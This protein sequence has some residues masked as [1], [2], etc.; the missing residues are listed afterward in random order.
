MRVNPE[1]EFVIG[2]YTVGGAT[3][4]AVIFGYYGE[5]GLIYA[6]RTRSGFTPQLRSELMK[7]FRPIETTECPF[8]NLPEARSGRWGFGLTAAKMS[9]CRWVLCRIRRRS[10]NVECRTMPQR[11]SAVLSLLHSASSCSA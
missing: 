11:V 2:G 1:Q 5:E 9:D 7:K 10:H 4:D 6:A 3:F 8:V